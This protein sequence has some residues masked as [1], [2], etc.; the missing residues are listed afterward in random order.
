MA[1][2]QSDFS[3]IPQVLK[4]YPHWLLFRHENDHKKPIRLATNGTL[5][6]FD[7]K[8]DYKY[9]RTFD[10]IVKLYEQGYGDGIGF[11]FGD[12][13]FMGIDFDGAF[14][15]TA[16][17]YIKRLASY[18][19]KSPSGQGYH[20]L[21]M[22]NLP[23]GTKNKAMQGK[24]DGVEVYDD[25]RYFTVTGQ[26]VAGT[27][28]TIA[29]PPAD[30]SQMLEEWGLLAT[31]EDKPSPPPVVVEDP[32]ELSDSTV[33]GLCRNEKRGQMFCD[34]FDNG[35]VSYHSDD[36]SRAVYWCLE[37][38]SFYTQDGEQISRIMQECALL[39][40]DKQRTKWERLAEKQVQKVL[41]WRADKDKY[42]PKQAQGAGDLF[43]FAGVDMPANPAPLLEYG[44][45]DL[46]NAER[47]EFMAGRNLMYVF[48]YGSFG[49]WNGLK[50]VIGDG[51]RNWLEG[52][53]AQ[54]MRD[55]GQYAFK[56][57]NISSDRL[58]ALVKFFAQC[59]NYSRI[60]GAV[61]VAKSIINN[62]VSTEQLDG[63]DLVI[64]TPQGI[65]DLTTMT[66]RPHDSAQLHTKVTRG[67]YITK[68][69]IVV[70]EWQ[71]FLDS[72]FPQDVQKWLQ[73]FFG[74]CLTGSTR[75]EKLLFLYG[76]GGSGK[77]TLVETINYALGDYGGVMPMET[78]L[79]SRNDAQGG[80][81]SASPHIMALMGKRLVL[82]SESGLGRAFNA[83]MLK[84]LTGGDKL[85]ARQ[86]HR[87]QCEF[88]PKFKLVISSNYMP[89]ISDPRDEGIKRRLLILP[90]NGEIENKDNGLKYRLR[91]NE[92]DIVF[93]WL[94]EGAY[95]YLKE[96]LKDIPKCI[97]EA[98]NAYY[99][100]NDELGDF[101]N[102]CTVPD[103]GGRVGKKEL[104]NRYVEWLDLYNSRGEAKKQKIFFQLMENTDYK[105]SKIHGVNVYTGLKFK[106]DVN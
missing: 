89:T 63:L 7:E 51:A 62:Q 29:R 31:K 37:K 66:T 50:W 94:V 96:G 69:D 72:I 75:E 87:Q 91:T 41:D 2:R 60:C 6:P 17:D 1:K 71:N 35:D 49:V 15:G 79:A 28:S 5:Y 16:G 80:G 58:Q 102:A 4:N 67:S 73:K 20:V 103:T 18:T 25:K 98:N 81:G 26:H 97:I 86:L 93:S 10:E 43:M 23:A 33:L 3:K 74:Y 46:G 47:L 24:H 13:P 57:Q 70:T 65:I 106:D 84:L 30:F 39:Q 42:T 83:S 32:V 34:V 27:P 88:Y 14:A 48:D 45:T 55:C 61:N 44:L 100:R 59:Q 8:K 92:K 22:G 11:Y 82:A 95:K 78:I 12:T 64:N 19:E 85:T 9:F 105:L 68:N 38:L 99:E 21:L 53:T 40:T 52:F 36:V 77:G 101:L 56:A 76:K 104:Y 90:F 54:L